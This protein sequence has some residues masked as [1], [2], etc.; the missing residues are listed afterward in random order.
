MRKARIFFIAMFAIFMSVAA[1]AQ[2]Q[3]A[4]AK[5]HHGRKRG[6]QKNVGYKSY[7]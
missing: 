7:H 6:D 3:T 1:S 5:N 2:L 4:G